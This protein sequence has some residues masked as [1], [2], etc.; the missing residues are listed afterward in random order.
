L[1]L[2]PHGDPN[3]LFPCPCRAQNEARTGVEVAEWEGMGKIQA[4]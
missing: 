4:N 2:K 1:G 3:G